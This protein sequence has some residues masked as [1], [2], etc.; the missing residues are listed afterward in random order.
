MKNITTVLLLAMALSTAA[1]D[2]KKPDDPSTGPA[3]MC[4]TASYALCIKA[5]CEKKSPEGTDV[6]CEC[7]MQSGWNLGP[8]SCEDRAK[9]LTS[10]YSNNF[11][12]YS[13]TVSCPAGKWAL[14]YG[15]KC[16]PHP[17]D[18]TKAICKCPV[19]E[20][21][22]VVLVARDQC[23]DPTK[24]CG[25]LWSAALPQENKFANEQFYNWMKD[26]GMAT[27][28]PAPACPAKP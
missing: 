8:G 17:N 2:T 21:P 5:P 24:I 25:I 15:A 1:E 19:K 14:C 26:H 4:N 16:E 11:N 23:S 18:P 20:T 10:T 7:L 6:L 27:N 13:A 28:P 3:V 9:T 22:F 12:P